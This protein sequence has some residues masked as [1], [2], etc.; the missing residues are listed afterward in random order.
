MNS[1]IQNQIK[2]AIQSHEL[3][4]IF[5]KPQLAWEN[6]KLP[7]TDFIDL[8]GNKIQRGDKIDFS[9]SKL[10]LCLDQKTPL[11]G[12]LIPKNSHASSLA[13]VLE[14]ESWNEIRKIVFG[15]TGWICIS[16]GQKSRPLE[17][18]ELWE[19][20]LKTKVGNF[21]QQKLLTLLPLCENCHSA[22]HG[23]KIWELETKTALE[24]AVRK[25][26]LF[27]DP[28]EYLRLLN[29]W[30]NQTVNFYKTVIRRRF[31]ETKN[32]FFFLNCQILTTLAPGVRFV[33]RDDWRQDRKILTH[34]KTGQ[35]TTI[36]GIETEI[37]GEDKSASI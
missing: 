23:T 32:L 14:W 15:A 16:C 11:V 4:K 30:D 28:L 36:L 19:I 17:L 34:I 22:A 24:K 26:E 12:W 18:H 13:N 8:S 37:K 29:C 7:F 6:I 35:K 21:H 27:D 10:P 1:T 20:N 5:G 2:E 3:T 33:I 25:K 9:D 31:I